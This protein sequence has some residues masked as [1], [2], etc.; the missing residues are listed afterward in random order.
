M[1]WNY[2]IVKSVSK[3]SGREY[4]SLREVEYDALEGIASISEE[5]VFPFGDTYNDLQRD[6]K[7]MQRAF[8]KKLIDEQTVVYG[9]LEGE[10]NDYK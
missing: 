4:F 3:E 10:Q 6:F 2:R 1:H 9:E 5:P 8:K 7:L